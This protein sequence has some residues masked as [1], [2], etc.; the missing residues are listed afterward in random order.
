MSWTPEQHR[1]FAAHFEDIF[2]KQA[3]VILAALAAPLARFPL[4]AVKE[5][6]TSIAVTSEKR[7]RPTLH[8]VLEALAANGVREDKPA[9]CDYC[10]GVR[11]WPIEFVV[12]QVDQARAM[13]LGREECRKLAWTSTR[14]DLA[15]NEKHREVMALRLDLWGKYQGMT[16]R[17]VVNFWCRWCAPSYWNPAFTTKRLN[18]G[19]FWRLDPSYGHLAND[20]KRA[21][22]G[23]KL[24]RGKPVTATEFAKDDVAWDEL[25]QSAADGNDEAR[26]RKLLKWREALGAGVRLESLIFPEEEAIK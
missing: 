16:T 8:A 24:F 21:I 15:P 20:L 2:G 22:E 25:L 14:T 13:E 6:L 1:E 17:T 19:K 4:Q 18:V 23:K 12:M 5:A 7:G 26:Y 9:V 3:N 10:D 11:S